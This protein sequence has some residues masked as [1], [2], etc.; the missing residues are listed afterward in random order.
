MTRLDRNSPIPLYFQLQELLKQEIDGG[1]MQPGDL[2]PSEAEITRRYHV[3]RTVIRKA[4]DILEQEGRVY[5]VKGKGT[6]V[7][8]PKFRYEAVGAAADWGQG[9][10]VRP[11]L[12]R[13]VSLRLVPAG[14]H[15]GRL[16]D[17]PSGSDV[18]E[19]VYVEVVE[20]TPASVTQMFL[21]VDATPELARSGAP[22][23]EPGGPEALIQLR[24]SYGLRL[25]RSQMTIEAT[26]TNEFEAELLGIPPRAPV[27]LLG[28]LE[29]DPDDRPVAF[30]RIIVR[31]DHFRFTMVL[32]HPEPPGSMLSSVMETSLEG[33][34]SIE[35]R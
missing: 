17:I 15:V 12:G 29:F 8:P 21:R 14:G 3:S 1:A 18:Y 9:D 6:I 25:P 30:S 7:A 11:T 10:G 19:L 31:S 24:E 5:R 26:Q 23:L 2:L 16:L 33:R 34:S 4:L 20:E 28:S 32:N 27:F 22:D 35:P 13:Q